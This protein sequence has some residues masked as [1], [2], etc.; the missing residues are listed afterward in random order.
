MEKTAAGGVA[1]KSLMIPPDEER[2]CRNDGGRW[3]C[4]RFR[5]T[6]GA[7]AAGGGLDTK[8]CEHHYNF[9]IEQH[10]KQKL[11]SNKKLKKKSSSEDDDY[12]S[13]SED[14][15]D[16]SSS[17]GTET[18]DSTFLEWKKVKYH[19]KGIRQPTANDTNSDIEGGSA[20]LGT[21]RENVELDFTT[22]KPSLITSNE[23][24]K[25]KKKEMEKKKL[26]PYEHRCC[27]ANGMGWRCKNFRMSHGAAA[28]DAS[29]PKTKFCE[30]HYNYYSKYSKN[31]YKKKKR[32]GDGEGAAGPIRRKRKT[33]ERMEGSG[34]PESSIKTTEPVVEFESME[35]Y[36]RKFFELSVDLEKK[37]AECIKLQGELADVKTGK[38]AA[39]DETEWAPEDATEYWRKMFSDL[40]SRVLR[41]ENENST[42]RSVES[43]VSNLESL[44][45]R[46]G[47]GDSILRCVDLHNSEKIES[48]APGL[49]NDKNNMRKPNAETSNKRRKDSHVDELNTEEKLLKNVFVIDTSKHHELDSEF[50]RHSA[51]NISSVSPNL[52]NAPENSEEEKAWGC[53]EETPPQAHLE[54]SKK[55]FVKLVSDNSGESFDESLGED[56]NSF[57][58][59]KGSLGCLMDMMPMKYRNRNNDRELKWK[60]EAD[61]LSSFDEDPE[62]CMKAVCA[63]YRQQISEGAKGLFHYSDA[64]RG[65]TLAKFLMD[66]ACKGDL[67]KSAKELEIFDSK[68]VEDSKRIARSYSKQLFNIYL[69]KKDPYFHPTTT[70]SHEDQTTN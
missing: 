35:N 57:I 27:H 55:T 22:Q 2:C 52:S 19:R 42:M 61:M 24:K 18:W 36:K 14:D 25:K 33:V 7:A 65:T 39:K 3:R 20:N 67:K 41:V 30:K 4:T 26:P 48:G 6:L 16:D 23:M 13:S 64:L 31:Y 53:G 9:K 38:N 32:S 17:S 56:S 45:L 69:N 47:K 49:Q 40:E 5:M 37:K 44:V 28:D 63:L 15:D 10:K 66:G 11:N 58:D 46:I 29:V 60:F 59:S 51:V 68:G 1:E 70:A 8:Y 34:E 54:M 62:L 21:K 12:S 43:R 50:P